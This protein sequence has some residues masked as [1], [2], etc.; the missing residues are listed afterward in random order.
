MKRKMTL[1][2]LAGFFLSLAFI[3]FRDAYAQ[4]PHHTDSSNNRVPAGYHEFEMF[5][6][7]SIYLSHYPMFGSI[8]AYQVIIEVNLK[9]PD[10]SNPK[11][12]YLSHK[13]KH[14]QARYSVS[15]ETADGKPHYWVLPETIQE[16][17]AFRANIHLERKAGPPVYLARNVTVEIKNLV[18]LRLFQPDDKKPMVLTYLLF[19]NDAETFM[20]HY[21]GN[22]PDFDQILSVRINSKNL[23]FNENES[24]A[25]V[26]IPSRNNDKALRLGAKDKTVVGHINGKGVEWQIDVGTEIHSELDLE[27]Q[28]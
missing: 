1:A 4:A 2:M 17:N 10:G 18:Y 13:Q 6:A 25:L 11:E 3:S 16:G 19:G 24:I 21:I 8:H 26:T 9:S 23:P 27:I 5:G 20:A 14:P 7:K 28:R 12:I 15:P 22:Y